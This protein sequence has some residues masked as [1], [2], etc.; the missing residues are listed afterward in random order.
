MKC[1]KSLLLS[2]NTGIFASSFS[3]STTDDCGVRVDQEARRTISSREISTDTRCFFG[4]HEKRY[5]LSCGTKPI[6][7]DI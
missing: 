3:I 4:T 5:Q 7:S 1:K 6:V 2:S